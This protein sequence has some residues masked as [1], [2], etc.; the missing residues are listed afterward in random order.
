MLSKA[1]AICRIAA[2]CSRV[3][4]AVLG[5]FGPLRERAII[6]DEKLELEATG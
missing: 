6:R 4:C 3:L 1:G 5:W 2:Q